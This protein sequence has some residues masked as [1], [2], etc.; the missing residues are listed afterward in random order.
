MLV[1]ECDLSVDM[2]PQVG[3]DAPLE[4]RPRVARSA[5]QSGPPVIINVISLH[6]PVVRLDKGSVLVALFDAKDSCL[7]VEK[8]R[9]QVHL[10]DLHLT[11]HHDY[12]LVRIGTFSSYYLPSQ[13]DASL[14]TVHE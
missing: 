2:L 1:L 3:M 13:T 6:Q 10:H 14:S 5:T 8:D 12:Y 7:V 11:T 9:G 4:L